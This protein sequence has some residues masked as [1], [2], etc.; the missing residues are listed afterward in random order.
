MIQKLLPAL[1]LCAVVALA[2]DPKPNSAPAPGSVSGSVTAAGTGTPMPDVEIYVNRGGPRVGHAVT[3]AQGRYV[4]RGLEPGQYRISANA[5]GP[6]GRIGGGPFAVRQVDLQAGQD[7][8]S[9]DFHLV[10]PG[11]IAGKVVD[12]NKEPVPGLAVFLVA[13]EYVSGALRAVFTGAA[14]TDDQGEYLLERVQAGRA[15]LVLAQ[16][17]YRRLDAISDA[18][19]DPRLRRPAVVPTYYPNSRSM[20]G[21]QALVL[22]SGELREGVDI[23][24][25]RAPSFCLEGVVEGGSGPADLHFEIGETQPTSGT[26]GN[27]GFYSTQPGG[28]PGPD[29]KIRICDLH[30]GDYELTV[31][32]YAKET[33]GA[34]PFFGSTVVTV[35][36]RDVQNVRVI[37]RPRI[38][39]AGEVVWDGPAPDPP[40]DAKLTLRLQAITR[41]ERGSVDATIPGE[42]SLPGGLLMDDFG[43]Q[44]SEVPKGVYIK[45][46]TYGG[47][48]ILYE[49]LRLGSAMGDAGLRI[50]LARDGGTASARVTDKDGNPVPE[51]SIVMIPASA[52]NEAT[53]AAALTTGK[54]DLRGTWTSASLAPGKYFVLA[55]SDTIDRSPES[56]AK[57]W[58]SRTRAQEVDLNPNA[59]ATLTL[60]PKSLE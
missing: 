54:T 40:L 3:D 14:S 17:R 11:R 21:A 33:F 55:T 52:A 50:V 6:G 4:L 56:I 60:T 9:F 12:Q 38:P 57:L 31:H 23:R 15:Y 47:H 7:L 20:D 59:T 35:A 26:S 25:V 8:E 51:C 13:R 34:A 10:L 46:I 44:V 29:G 30:Q 19:A 49:P 22:S 41:T 1:T 2:Q 53:I 45:D 48:S 18:P 16:R 58:A 24:L 28:T 39:L 43:L 42:F 36:D 37:A 5:P 32:Q 27:G